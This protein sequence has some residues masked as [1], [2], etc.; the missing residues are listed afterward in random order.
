MGGQQTSLLTL[1]TFGLAAQARHVVTATSVNALLDAWAH[2]APLGP[3]LLLGAG[4]N[5]LFTENFCGTVVLNRLKGIEVRE[6]ATH[7]QLHIG[8]G[9]N[10]HDLVEYALQ[11]GIGGLE[12]LALIPGCV[13][14]APVQNIGAYGV[15]FKDVC[16]YV[17]V[18]DLQSGQRE[19]LTG[20]ACQ[21]G[22]RDSLFKRQ[23][24]DHYAIIAVGLALP[25]RWRPVL[26]YG[27]LK[28]LD[29]EQATP[30]QVFD[31]VCRVRRQKLPDPRQNG[32][33]GSFFKNPVISAARAAELL[34]RYPQ[35]PHYP[36][37]SGEV[38]LAAGWLIDQCQ[39]KGCQIGGAAV[40]QQQALVLINTGQATGADVVALARHVRHRVGE[41]FAVWLEPEVRF[42]GLHGEQDAVE[43]LA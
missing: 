12:N 3:V 1:N 15:E 26:S 4:S 21:F 9:E 18:L 19:R 25:K 30:R 17:D 13:G 22:Y 40:H 36:Q 43:R 33:A 5:V 32:N 24:R 31:V 37:P 29:A 41:Q 16:D 39:L 2:Y 7:W 11:R 6:T 8:A 28:Q 38:K 42:I 27:E 10:W 14:S 34:A 20:D 23:Y 35:M